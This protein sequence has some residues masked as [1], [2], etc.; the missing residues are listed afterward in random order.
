MPAAATALRSALKPRPT[1]C[2]RARNLQVGLIDG[3]YAAAEGLP[4]LTGQPA[5][6]RVGHALGRRTV[7]HAR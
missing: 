7:R 2:G 1:G 3:R 5:A 6:F 4:P